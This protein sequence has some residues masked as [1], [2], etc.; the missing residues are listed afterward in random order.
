[1][2][3]EFPPLVCSCV[4]PMKTS[5]LFKETYVLVIFVYIAKD[6]KLLL[7]YLSVYRHEYASGYYGVLPF[8]LSKV[9]IDVL[10]SRLIP[11]FIFAIVIYFMIGEFHAIIAAV[12]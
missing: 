7:L 8:F 10:V 4:M 5:S 12:Y 9:L 3:R 2:Q 1:M 6:S 11:N